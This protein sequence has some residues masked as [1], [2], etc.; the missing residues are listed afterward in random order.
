[1]YRFLSWRFR[2]TQIAVQWFIWHHV[3]T[4]KVPTSG[5]STRD[6]RILGGRDLLPEAESKRQKLGI[7]VQTLLDGAVYKADFLWSREAQQW[8]KQRVLLFYILTL[9]LGTS[10]LT[11]A[12][13]ATK[14]LM[15]KKPEANVIRATEAPV[16]R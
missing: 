2:A 4:K 13:F 9:V 1:M 6:L 12:S 15:T 5:K 11:G 14:V 8:V 3:Y 16:L 7:D 10:A